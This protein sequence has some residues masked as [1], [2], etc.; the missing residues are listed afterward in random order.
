MKS[1]E[2]FLSARFEMLPVTYKVSN[3]YVKVLVKTHKSKFY[4]QTLSKDQPCRKFPFLIV[5][6]L[7]SLQQGV[8][9]LSY[10]IREV[11]KVQ[12]RGRVCVDS[13][14][15]CEKL[16]SELESFILNFTCICST[17]ISLT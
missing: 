7:F 1:V 12:G 8:V 16:H 15:L 17:M 10:G 13:D 4:F 9:R 14:N 5:C 3:N 6:T 11:K 2:G